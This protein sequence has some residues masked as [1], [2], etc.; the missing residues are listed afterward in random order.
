MKEKKHPAF[1]TKATTMQDRAFLL[2]NHKLSL[3]TQEQRETE[4]FRLSSQLFR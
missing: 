3:A 2:L 4:A 1:N